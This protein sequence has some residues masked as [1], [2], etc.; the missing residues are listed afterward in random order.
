[1]NQI[2]N[3]TPFAFFF[4]AEDD[5][6]AFN[7]VTEFRKALFVDRLGWKL[8]VSGQHEVDEFD[9]SAALYAVL[10][11]QSQIRG[12]FRAI[13]AD[14]DYL[15]EKIFPNLA[16]LR[17]YPKQTAYWEISR[18]GVWPGPEARLNSAMLYAL[19][20]QFALIRRAKALVAVT[21]LFHERYLSQ[22]SIRT[23]RYGM[24]QAC[25]TDIRGRPITLVAGE[26]PI[27]SQQS[28]ALRNLFATLNGVSINDKA[29]VFGRSRLQA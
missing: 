17:S 10:A 28:E 3:N 29:L 4:K 8:Q 25:G 18:F 11:D 26:I 9:T 2:N 1:M 27:V 19:M 16:T 5:Q 23:R 21:D 22:R 15:A 7:S 12:C 20:F 24:P 13:R 6:D 14:S